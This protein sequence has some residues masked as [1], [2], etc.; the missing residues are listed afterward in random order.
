MMTLA[1]MMHSA[2]APHLDAEPAQQPQPQLITTEVAATNVPHRRTPH[3]AVLA[4]STQMIL[5]RKVQVVQMHSSPGQLAIFKQRGMALA[6]RAG[7]IGITEKA[8]SQGGGHVLL[9]KQRHWSCGKAGLPGTQR[10][11]L[12]LLKGCLRR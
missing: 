4:G 7:A 11:G 3:M 10:M 8:A 9:N 5:A 2:Q 6:V 12:L 1:V